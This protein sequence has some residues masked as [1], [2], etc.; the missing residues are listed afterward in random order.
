MKQIK[1]EVMSLISHL[2]AMLKEV[3]INEAKRRSR[4]KEIK[5]KWP[6]QGPGCGVQP[7]VRDE[8]AEYDTGTYEVETRMGSTPGVFQRW[9]WVT[10]DLWMDNAETLQEMVTN[11][12]D[13]LDADGC[14]LC[15]GWAEHLERAA[16]KMRDAV[17]RFKSEAIG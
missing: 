16:R 7:G 4:A 5:K 10:A 14:K 13:G 2:Q 8:H 9:N 15:L 6:R 3:T 12:L 1:D 17:A 11:L